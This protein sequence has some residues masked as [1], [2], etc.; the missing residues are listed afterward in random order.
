MTETYIIAGSVLVMLAL[1]ITALALCRSA[2]RAD[3]EAAE[4]FA[5]LEDN[6]KKQ[7]R[8]DLRKKG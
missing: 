7:V 5:L 1:N 6:Y 8:D 3:R 4:H 2:A